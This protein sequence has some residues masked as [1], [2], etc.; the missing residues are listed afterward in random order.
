MS[1]NQ[2]NVSKQIIKKMFLRIKKNFLE[3]KISSLWE[4]VKWNWDLKLCITYL[5]TGIDHFT[6]TFRLPTFSTSLKTLRKLSP[7]NFLRSSSDHAPLANRDANKAGY[8]DTSSSP[9]GVLRNN[10]STYKHCDLH[11]VPT[12][13]KWLH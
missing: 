1:C 10:V 3:K 2:I 8:F 5:L 12:N 4:Y 11:S 13:I 6:V 9:T 7:A